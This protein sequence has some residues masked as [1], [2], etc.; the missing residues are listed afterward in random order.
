MPASHSCSVTRR[1]ADFVGGYLFGTGTGFICSTIGLTLDSWVTFLISRRFGLPLVQRFVGKE[2]MDNFDYLM[3]HKG[4]L[5]SFVFFLIPGLPKDSF[6]YLLGRSTMHVLTFVVI[7]TVRRI[8]GTLLL[9]PQGEAVRAEEYRGFFVVLGLGLTAIVLALIYRDKIE[10]W[11]K[12]HR[13]LQIL[14]GRRTK[15]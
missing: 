12:H 2:N 8:P 7:S 15:Q 4:A 9:S 5:F 10:H 14:L 1:A 6:C 13:H 3:V 11:L